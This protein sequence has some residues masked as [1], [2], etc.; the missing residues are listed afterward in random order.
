MNIIIKGQVRD[1]NKKPVEIKLM[2]YDIEEMIEHKAKLLCID[3]YE[4]R[5]LKHLD[6]H[7]IAVVIHD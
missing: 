6:A 7:V 1:E 3:G 2:S 5:V 4:G